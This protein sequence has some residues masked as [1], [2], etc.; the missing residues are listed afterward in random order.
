M[1]YQGW[2]SGSRMS[3]SR[4]TYKALP[5][6][7]AKRPRLA[8]RVA[9]VEKRQSL[10]GKPEFKAIYTHVASGNT[11]TGGAG[12]LTLLNGC[13]TGSGLSSRDGRQIQNKSVQI[14]CTYVTP[15]AMT[16]PCI[17]RCV[18]FIDKEPNGSSPTIGKVL[19]TNQGNAEE[20]FRNLQYRKRFVILKDQRFVVEA[21]QGWDT[22][23]AYYK[24]VV[25]DPIKYK[26]LKLNTIFNSGT[27][28]TI[29]DIENG[30]LYIMWFGTEATYP[31][32][33]DCNAV[34]RFI[35]Y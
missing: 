25:K 21:H 34:V 31:V 33:V 16:Q 32:V 6:K 24:R 23:G 28:G 18:V 11:Y 2:K 8:K 7:G 3:I 15:A 1:G 5:K 22:A 26:K 17:M 19:D 29:A 10:L 14:N 35:D 13:T 9:Q 27:A 20:T 12:L 30:A 4:A